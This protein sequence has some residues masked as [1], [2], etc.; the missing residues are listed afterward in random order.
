MNNLLMRH[1]ES[2]ISKRA[3][4]NSN[5][6]KK[7]DGLVVALIG[8]ACSV[9]LVGILISRIINATDGE[10]FAIVCFCA[11]SVCSCGLFIAYLFENKP[12][13]KD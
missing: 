8:I 2:T 9:P 6:M 3:T 10:E 1:S 4:L 13:T 5:D 12:P 11:L 7:K